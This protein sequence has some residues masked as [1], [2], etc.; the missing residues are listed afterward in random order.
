MACALL[1]FNSASIILQVFT[2]NILL[3][4]VPCH[5]FDLLKL[6]RVVDIFALNLLRGHNYETYT[7]GYGKE[8]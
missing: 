6:V 8:D 5:S 4:F 3:F 1:L 2:L 7:T